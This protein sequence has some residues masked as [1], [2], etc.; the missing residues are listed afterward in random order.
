MLRF[1]D[2]RNFG[3]TATGIALVVGPVLFLISSIVQPNTDHKDK[4]RELAAVSAH[5]G[6]Y[7]LSGI[8]FLVAAAV[9][10]FAAFGLVKLFRGPRGVTAGQ[11]AGFLLMLGSAVTFGWYALGAIEYEMVNQKGVNRAAMAQFLHKADNTS[12]LLP[13]IL[14][15]LI[16]TVL[17]LVLLGIAAWRTGL[18]PRWTAILLIVSGPF[19]F[20][21]NGRAASIVQNAV[22]LIALGM[23]SRSILSMSDEEWDSPRERASAPP[24]DAPAAPAPAPAM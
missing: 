16:G 9:L 10:M 13:L 24:A 6:T 19:G 15:F 8:L 17:G 23:L 2:A 22:M 3:R 1:S 4:L 7:F 20:F 14:A 12:S 21:A 18:V 11:V 5:K